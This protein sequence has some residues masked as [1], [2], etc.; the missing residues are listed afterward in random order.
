MSEYFLRTHVK[1]EINVY[2]DSVKVSEHG[3]IRS[4][5]EKLAREGSAYFSDYVD[6]NTKGAKNFLKG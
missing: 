6:G 4:D 2:D 3:C 5:D 1:S